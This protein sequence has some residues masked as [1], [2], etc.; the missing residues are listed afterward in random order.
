MDFSSLSALKFIPKVRDEA[1]TFTLCLLTFLRK[2]LRLGNVMPENL[3]SNFH[4][5]FPSPHGAF[6]QHHP[7]HKVCV[8]ALLAAGVSDAPTADH[9]YGLTGRTASA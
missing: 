9:S 5:V 8:F 7:V 3:F 4:P 1:L 2:G 6:A